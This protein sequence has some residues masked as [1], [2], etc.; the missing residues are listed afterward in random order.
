MLKLVNYVSHNNAQSE[1]STVSCTC[2]VESTELLGLL[3]QKISKAKTES[4]L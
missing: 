4:S 3:L 1:G 2:T